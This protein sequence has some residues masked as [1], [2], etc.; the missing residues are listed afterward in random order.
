M[1]RLGP[2]PSKCFVLNENAKFK[3]VFQGADSEFD[4]CF[5]KVSKLGKF[6]QKILKCFV[7]NGTRYKGVFKCALFKFNHFS[8]SIPRN[9][10]TPLYN[11][12]D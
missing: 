1:D 7:L 9:L 4:N 11:F 5:L 8:K 3:G 2:E 6:G 10:R 12:L